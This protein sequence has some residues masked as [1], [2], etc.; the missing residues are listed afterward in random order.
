MHISNRPIR[1]HSYK[2]IAESVTAFLK[3]EKFDIYTFL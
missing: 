3:A 2:K 1:I